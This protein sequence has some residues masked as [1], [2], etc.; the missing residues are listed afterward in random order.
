M[1]S[2]NYIFFEKEEVRYFKLNMLDGG[3]Q[4]YSLY[5]KRSDG[6]P[7]LRLDDIKNAK[8]IL[9]YENFVEQLIFYIKDYWSSSFEIVRITKVSEEKGFELVFDVRNNKIDIEHLTEIPGR[10]QV[11]LSNS[12]MLF[13]NYFSE[14]LCDRSSWHG[15]LKHEK[16][17]YS[18]V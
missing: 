15:S 16:V 2:N 10:D 12:L 18:V 6:R 11:F 5:T 7:R 9:S 3:Y 1:S 8:S 14:F 17:L 4:S 13:F